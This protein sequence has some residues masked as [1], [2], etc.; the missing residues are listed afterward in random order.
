M[1][2]IFA[3]INRA[4]ARDTRTYQLAIDQA[5]S[6]DH[7]W[8]VIGVA[9]VANSPS[10]SYLPHLWSMSLFSNTDQIEVTESSLVTFC[11]G[12]RRNASPNGVG[13]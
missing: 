5:A 13:P 12:R 6:D 9:M 2:H 1:Q 10:L 8:M 3:L 4:N 11:E 7:R